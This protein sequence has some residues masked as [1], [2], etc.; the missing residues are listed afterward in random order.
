MKPSDSLPTPLDK[1]P[2]TTLTELSRKP[3]AEGFETITYRG[4]DGYKYEASVK[5]G[6][7]AVQWR[8][9]PAEET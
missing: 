9:L 7:I 6:V 5:D 8:R 4:D 2:A 1:K 3:A